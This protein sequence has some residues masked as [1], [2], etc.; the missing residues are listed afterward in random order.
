MSTGTHKKPARKAKRLSKEDI[1]AILGARDLRNGAQRAS[2]HY[3][4]SRDR[5]RRIWKADNPYDYVEVIEE[6]GPPDWFRA[7]RSE[8]TSPIATESMCIPPEKEGLEPPEEAKGMKVHQK[9]PKSPDGEMDKAIRRAL[10]A[11][12]RKLTNGV[13][14]E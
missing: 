4:I 5:V 3:G 10:R 11:E 7:S 13:D 8:L 9:R 6:V 2:D 1:D 12:L 14:R